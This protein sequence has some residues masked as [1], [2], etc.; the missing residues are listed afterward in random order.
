MIKTSFGVC[1]VYGRVLLHKLHQ[2]KLFSAAASF[3]TGI[4]IQCSY[5]DQ[6]DDNNTYKQ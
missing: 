6:S 3:Y 4:M 2:N 1:H 5:D